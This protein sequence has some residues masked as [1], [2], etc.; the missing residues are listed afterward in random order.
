MRRDDH[1][2]RG[3]RREEGRR[4]EGEEGR[5]AEGEE[6]DE[7]REMSRSATGRREQMRKEWRGEGRME[8]KVR[9][10]TRK[11]TPDAKIRGEG[12]K[13]NGRLARMK[14]VSGCWDGYSS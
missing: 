2:R 6:G 9:R 12:M 7:Q 11:N 13:G 4:G 10:R 1:W 8:G 3:E 14:S 5:R